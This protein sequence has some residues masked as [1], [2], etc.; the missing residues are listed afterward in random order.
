MI[1]IAFSELFSEIIRTFKLNLKI[2]FILFQVSYI[3]KYAVRFRFKDEHEYKYKRI[4]IISEKDNPI[5]IG[6]QKDFK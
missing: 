3:T 4:T 1:L 6:V 5:N 2:Y